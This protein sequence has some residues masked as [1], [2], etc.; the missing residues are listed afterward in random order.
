MS[1]GVHRWQGLLMRVDG[2]H[3]AAILALD[4]QHA[5]QISQ[6]VLIQPRALLQ[7]FEAVAVVQQGAHLLKAAQ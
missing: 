3:L 4:Q 7:G 5:V 6:H 2:N 1:N